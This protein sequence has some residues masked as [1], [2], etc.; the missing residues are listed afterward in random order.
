[1]PFKANESLSGIETII[2]GLVGIGT[3]S[4]KANESLSG[5]ETYSCV[6]LHARSGLSKLMNPYQGLKHYQGA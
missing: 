3:V 1:M 4:F 6:I 2:L 5:I